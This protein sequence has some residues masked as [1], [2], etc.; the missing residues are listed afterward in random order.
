MSA[1]LD[2]S[3]LWAPGVPTLVH[4]FSLAPAQ[5]LMASTCSLSMCQ[6]CKCLHGQVINADGDMERTK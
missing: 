5:C 3:G 1:C 4:C 6:F 2:L